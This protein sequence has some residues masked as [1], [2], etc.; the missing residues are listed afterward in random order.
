MAGI[1]LAQAE[2]QLVLWLQVSEDIASNGQS[3][4]IHGRDFRAADLAT[5][6]RQIDYWDGKVKQLARGSTGLRVRGITP[7]G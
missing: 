4:A 1:T 7:V 2:A 3:T 6:Q 5:V